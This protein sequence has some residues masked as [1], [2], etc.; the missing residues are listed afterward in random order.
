MKWRKFFADYW[1]LV[2]SDDRVFANILRH[3]GKYHAKSRAN[4][5]RKSFNTLKEAKAYAG[6]TGE[7][8]ADKL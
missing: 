8:E 2:D 4:Q 6:E 7:G 3:G 1:S 5:E